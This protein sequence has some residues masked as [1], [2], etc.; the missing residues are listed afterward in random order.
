MASITRYDQYFTLIPIGEKIT[1][2]NVY[3]HIGYAAGININ[4][5][6]S[7]N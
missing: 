4:C 7:S 5:H 1:Y 2:Y 3:Q 6:C